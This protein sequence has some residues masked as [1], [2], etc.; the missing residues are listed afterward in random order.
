MIAFSVALRGSPWPSVFT[1]L[2]RP[3]NPM[4]VSI[5]RRLVSL[6]LWLVPVSGAL[7]QGTSGSL[8]DPISSRDLAGYAERLALSPQQLQALEPFF[9]EYRE[10]F[11][12]LRENEIEDYLGGL[13]GMWTRGFRGLDRQAVEESL[14]KSERVESRI[15][16]VDEHFF[17]QLSTL[18]DDEQAAQLPRV[19]QARDRQRRR[20]GAA[21]MIG[22]AN[23]AARVDLSSLYDDLELDA[24]ARQET[25]PFIVIY[26]GRLT[27]LTKEFSE[28]S[29]RMFLE[30]LDSLE[31]QNVVFG[32]LP[33]EQGRGRMR[34]AMSTAWAAARKKPLEKAAAISDLNLQTLRQVMALLPDEQARLLRN[35][36]LRLAYPEIPATTGSAERSFRAAR[37]LEG[38]PPALAGDIETAA[39]AFRQQRDTVIDEMVSFLDASRRESSPFGL[40]GDARREHEEKLDAYRERL[41]A[42]DAATV[43]AL[44]ALLGEE[45]AERVRIAAAAPDE[46][47]EPAGLGRP[48]GAQAAV[49]AAAG[50]DPYL[51]PPISSR[52]VRGYVKRLG[53][54]DND[55]FILESLHEDYLESWRTQSA[56]RVGALSAAKARMPQPGEE[57]AARATAEQIDELYALRAAAMQSLLQLDGAFF[58]DLEA[59]IAKPMQQATARRLR[60]ERERLVYNRG[61][62]SR[63]DALVFGEQGGRNRWRGPAELVSRES[64]ID[65]AALLDGLDPEAAASDKVRAVLAD[66]ESAAAAG[67][68]RQ[69]DAVASLRREAEKLTAAEPLGQPGERDGRERWRARMEAYQKLM[70]S[71]GAATAEA[72]K[73]MVDLNR[74]TLASLTAALA[75]QTAEALQDAYNTAAFPE[76][77]DDP[78]AADRF[79]AAAMELPD[80]TTDQRSGVDAIRAEYRPAS[81]EILSRMAEIAA[82]SAQ[83]PRGGFDPRRFG[84]QEEERNKLSRLRFERDEVNAKAMR[85]LRGLLTEQQRARIRLP[86]ETASAPEDDRAL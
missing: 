57:Q 69:F 37:R 71:Q 27:S 76:I 75:A 72:R 84:A 73:V 9:D 60:L 1:L 66:Y 32:E 65:V 48:D 42:L 50:P 25:E 74:A 23:R 49:Q 64:D 20:T 36:Y 61:L 4:R 39:V 12:V 41:T 79:L 19:L 14:E 5:A 67:F 35:R 29:S 77:Y 63:I 21:G 80:L 2:Q 30:V 18:L 17:N 43:D 82:S 85:Q 68:R 3:G 8:P 13:T 70:E 62:D 16:L 56:A 45:L 51:A 15:R 83:A 28:A 78:K 22:G 55:R 7:A 26:E 46:A 47:E 38:M 6:A 58:D 53:L 24:Q 10:A 33:D 11:R 40:R 81:R 54:D 44:L 59:L 86:D 31:E 52:D 34:E